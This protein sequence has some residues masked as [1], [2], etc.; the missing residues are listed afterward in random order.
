MDERGAITIVTR[1]EAV[2]GSV[3]VAI[4]DTGHGIPPEQIDRIFDPFF[5]IKAGGQG[6]GLGLSIAY[7][8]V[9][10]HRGTISVHSEGGI[11]SMFTIR[12]PGAPAGNEA[13]E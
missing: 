4:S 10:T 5:T 11:G 8:I 1:H 12:M 9:T 7:G 13:L 3:E 6:T 2:A